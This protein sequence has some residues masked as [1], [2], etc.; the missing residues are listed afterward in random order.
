MCT[1]AI[2]YERAKKKKLEM[3]RCCCGA[4]VVLHFCKMKDSGPGWWW[5]KAKK[6]FALP[7]SFLTSKTGFIGINDEATMKGIRDC[8]TDTHIFIKDL[9]LGSNNKER[10]KVRR[11]IP[12]GFLGRK[13]RGIAKKTLLNNVRKC[14]KCYE[15]YG[16]GNV[17]LVARWS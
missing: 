8:C 16:N 2:G 7:Y 15:Y 5:A 12:K 9:R 14:F 17:Y 1:K 11:R 4:V 6:L 3:H 10:Q 13:K